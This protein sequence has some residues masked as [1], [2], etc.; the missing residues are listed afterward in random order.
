MF[1]DLTFVKENSLDICPLPCPIPIYNVDGTLNEMGSVCEEVEVILWID[2]HSKQ[3]VFSMIGLGKT[4]LIIGHTWLHHHTPEIDWTMGKITLTHCPSNCCVTIW[5]L[6]NAECWKGRKGRNAMER[7]TEDPPPVEEIIEEPLEKGDAIFAAYFPSNSEHSEIVR[8]TSMP[9]Q[10]LVEAA[11]AN[12]LQKTFEELV[13]EDFRDIFSK[14]S[15]DQLPQQKLWDHHIEFK[16]GTQRPPAKLFPLSP[17]EQKELNDFLK[18][19]LASGHI[20]PS[21]YPMAAPV[22]FV[23]KKDRGFWLVQD[24]WKLNDVTVKNAYPLPLISDIIDQLWGAKV[25]GKLDL[26]WGF[27]N[28]WMAEGEEWKAA[29]WT[30]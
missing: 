23:K 16:E 8:A 7:P 2:D 29:F 15:F 27:Q 19:N 18:E 30:N 28:I 22:F 21:K 26:R 5:K 3:V 10:R 11:K 17:S 25:F 14:D 9:S 6:W 20:C 13:P 1:T 12:E 4:K 24:Y